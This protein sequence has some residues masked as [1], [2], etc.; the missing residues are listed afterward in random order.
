[1]TLTDQV[2]ACLDE[3]K[4]P[5]SVA[6]G[7]PEGLADM[8]IIKSVDITPAGDVT[9]CLR[10]TSPFCEMLGFMRRAIFEKLA[11]VDGIGEV[12]ILTDS[13]MD[14]SVREMSPAAQRRREARLEV[15]RSA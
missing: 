4:D 8:G 10:L 11:A 13:G 3:V 15:L 1:M 7:T 14:W 5:C 12:E 9:I 6:N 2:L